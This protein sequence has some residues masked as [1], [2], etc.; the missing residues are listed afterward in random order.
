[1]LILIAAAAILASFAIEEVIHRLRNTYYIE[2]PTP[3]AEPRNALALDVAQRL[4]KR[5]PKSERQVNG[6]F[7]V[8]SDATW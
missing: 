7:K 2:W 8:A 5:E 6:T 1:M 3:A 4:R